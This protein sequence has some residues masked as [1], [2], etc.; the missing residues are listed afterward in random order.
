MKY[1]FDHDLHIHS[2]LSLCSD[3]PEQS[4]ENILNYAKRYSLSTVCVTDHFWDSSVDGA[5]DWYSGQNFEHIKKILPLPKDDGTRF[6]FG[7]ET[8]MNRFGTV[9][10]FRELYDE[11]DFVIIPTTHFHM[12]GYTLTDE[13][14]ESPKSRAEAWVRRFDTLLSLDIPFEKVG[15]AHLICAFIGM[16]KDTVHET[17]AAIPESEMYRLFK[18]SAE[19]GVGIELNASDMRSAMKCPE[20]LM[21]PFVIAKECGCKFYLGTDAH[22]PKAFDIAKG[23][24]E[25]AIDCLELKESDKFII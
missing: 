8:E 5:S 2:H 16:T 1:K 24:F 13:E 3:D 7:C 17:V 15:V 12:R 21:K 4:A 20:I 19:V 9:G 25:W 6:L 18:R 22:H 11:F 14:L 23:T 10:I